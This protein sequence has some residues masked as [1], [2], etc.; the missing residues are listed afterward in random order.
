MTRLLINPKTQL[1]Y[2]PDLINRSKSLRKQGILTEV[3]FW[4]RVKNKQLNN[5]DF[6]RQQ[7]IGHYIVDFYC[8]ALSLVVEIDGSSHTNKSDYDKVRDEY[9]NSLGLVVLH[10]ID[11]DVLKN[12]DG[13]LKHLN[14]FISSVS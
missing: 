6:T 7:I 4:N 13:A 12:L 11:T 10:Y 8:H 2:N 1:P 14:G 5:L 9:L 3:L